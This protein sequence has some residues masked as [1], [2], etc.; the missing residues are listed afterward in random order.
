[1]T[2]SGICK[3]VLTIRVAITVVVMRWNGSVG[4]PPATEPVQMRPLLAGPFNTK[5]NSPKVCEQANDRAVK[6]GIDR[7][8]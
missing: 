3:Q 4:N 1:M 8:T 5:N 6:Q 2:R 7:P